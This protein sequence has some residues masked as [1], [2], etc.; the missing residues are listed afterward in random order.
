MRTDLRGK[1]RKE[2]RNLDRDPTDITQSHLVLA[3]SSP[4]PIFFFSSV[5]AVFIFLNILFY[6]FFTELVTVRPC[7]Y[8]KGQGVVK[9]VDKGA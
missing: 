8:G 3:V 6:F 5:F 4:A 2:E 9:I 1:K 7:S